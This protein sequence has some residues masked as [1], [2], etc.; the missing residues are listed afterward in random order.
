M[1]SALSIDISLLSASDKAPQTESEQTRWVDDRRNQKA[2][3]KYQKANG[4]PAKP[5]LRDVVLT[6]AF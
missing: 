6:F 2:K 5:I 4:L 1:I 3:G